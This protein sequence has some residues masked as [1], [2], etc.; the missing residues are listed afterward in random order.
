M[1][2]LPHVYLDDDLKPCIV[3]AGEEH[4]DENGHDMNDQEG[5]QNV[6]AGGKSVP[7]VK[8]SRK[9]KQQQPS[10]EEKPKVQTNELVSARSM[11]ISLPS[12]STF[13]HSPLLLLQ[14]SRV[15]AF[16]PA[17]WTPIQ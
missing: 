1:Q 11:N 8:R 15:L 3:V 14:L 5:W 9:R 7:V 4:P 12:S 6:A 16:S 2:R 17:S 10:K 13:I